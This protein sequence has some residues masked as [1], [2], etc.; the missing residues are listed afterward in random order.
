MPR[1]RAGAGATDRT[2][3]PQDESFDMQ[4]WMK[5]AETE[6]D[7]KNDPKPSDIDNRM[8]SEAR[9]AVVEGQAM[10]VAT[11]DHTLAPTGRSCWK[12]R[13]LPRP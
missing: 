13:R 11:M 3:A 6:G 4:K 9:E 10:V 7:K 1:T 5:A 2:H 12:C 8:E